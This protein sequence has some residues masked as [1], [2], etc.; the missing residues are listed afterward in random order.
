MNDCILTKVLQKS[1]NEPRKRV[2]KTFIPRKPNGIY[3][4]GEFA[5]IN[6][7]ERHYHFSGGS[8]QE[9]KKMCR[10]AN[11]EFFDCHHDMVFSEYKMP[12]LIPSTFITDWSKKNPFVKPR[13][14]EHVDH[15][16][17][18]IYDSNCRVVVA[19][20]DLSLFILT[21]E[22]SVAKWRGS[23]MLC[24]IQ[25]REIKVIPTYAPSRIL[26]VWDWRHIAMY[27]LQRVQTES[28]ESTYR[29]R[30]DHFQIGPTY[31]EACAT[32]EWLLE[33]YLVGDNDVYTP[34]RLISHDVETIA[35]N[36]SVSGLAW[37]ETDAICIPFMTTQE[38][39]GGNHNY[40]T[41][42]EEAYLVHLLNSILTHPNARVVGQNYLYDMQH[43]AKS[44][45]IR[46]N[47]HMDTMLA[48]HTIF[49]GEKKSLD[50]LASIF[51]DYY[52]YWKDELKDYNSYPADETQYWNYNCKDCCYTY[53]I[54]VKLTELL[55]SADLELQYEFQ[56]SMYHPVFNAMLRGVRVD[57]PLRKTLALELFE[58][59]TQLEA[60]LLIMS[61]S[62]KP[63]GTKAQTY[64]FNSP[65]QT[66]AFFYEYLSLPKQINRATK[67]P[68]CD[69]EALAI[70]GEKEPVVRPICQTI[71]ELRSVNIFRKNF[72][73]AP[74]GNDGRI[75]CSYNLAGTET[76]RLSSSKDA[77]GQGANLQTIPKGGEAE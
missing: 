58:V 52:C 45:G 69:D 29:R 44:H 54:A 35:R 22:K 3:L 51:C 76:F 7:Q 21:G 9:L 4:L 55:A 53:E 61:N 25:G 11:F 48:W 10:E 15:V 67:R 27:D 47:V 12:L 66:Q 17:Q 72:L 5:E 49:P 68:S 16:K 46:P 20:G 28:L 1:A 34:P 38:G 2:A 75:R 40:W 8:G 26:K 31:D 23:R 42:D 19:L 77:F 63:E 71:S 43:E 64:W 70:L 18:S 62:Y 30:E 65:Q 50:F 60:R 73:E 24:N 36:I 33:S 57:K 13:W 56:M 39:R 59:A 6:D 32:L 37:S 14:Q 74:L 41:V